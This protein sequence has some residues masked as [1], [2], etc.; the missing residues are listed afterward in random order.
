MN[1]IQL[2]EYFHRNQMVHDHHDQMS[3]LLSL[4][5]EKEQRLWIEKFYKTEK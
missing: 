4:F 5:E 1:D 3:N 2:N